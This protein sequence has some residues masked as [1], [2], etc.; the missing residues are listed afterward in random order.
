MKIKTIISAIIILMIASCKKDWENHYDVYPETVN[1]NVWEVLQNKSEVSEFVEAL[2][3]FKYDTLFSSD[4]SYTV[5]AP[6]NEAWSNYTATN[7]LDTM[8][9]NYLIAPAFV[10]S[11]SIKGKRKIQTRGKK[12]AL[13]EKNGNLTFDGVPLTDESPLYRNGK[14][15]IMEEVAE[16]KPNLYDYYKVHNPVLKEYIDSQDSIVLDLERS[17]PTGFNPEGETIY[18]SVTIVYNKFEEEYFPVSK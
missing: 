7:E 4:I 15:Y 8:L 16:P 9:L 12:F 3:D 13:F 11:E 14:Y 5:F 18:D 1:Q 10:Q 6:T 17:T 2:K